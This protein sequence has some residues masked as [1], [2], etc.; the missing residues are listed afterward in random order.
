MSFYTDVIKKD[1]RFNTADKVDDVNL[2]ESNMRRKVAAI[3]SDAASAGHKLKVIETFRSQARQKQLYDN[4]ASKLEHVGVHN[5]GLATDFVFLNEDGSPN[6]GADYS[7]LG[8]I[9]K[10]HNLV[11]GGDWIFK[12][13]GH[14]QFCAVKD[15]TKLFNLSWYPDENY[16]PLGV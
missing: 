8:H 7:V 16:N 14:V 1:A 10:A 15:Q 11:W 6:W 9:A 12:D 4:G 2:L 5:F 13:Y 3:I